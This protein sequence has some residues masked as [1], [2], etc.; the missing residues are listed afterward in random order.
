MARSYD[1]MYIRDSAEEDAPYKR[2]NRC[3]VKVQERLIQ[4][5]FDEGEA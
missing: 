2:G 3:S 4:K 5:I 1:L